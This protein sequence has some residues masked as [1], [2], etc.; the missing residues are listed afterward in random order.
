[1]S[2]TSRR[3]RLRLTESPAES[4]CVMAG[5][6]S[7]FT[8]TRLKNG[9]KIITEEI[10]GARSVSLGFWIRTGS[11]DEPA[12]KAGITHFLEHLIFKGTRS[13][14]VRDIAETFDSIGGDLNAFSSKEYTCLYARVVDHHLDVAVDVLSDLFLHPTLKQADLEAER[15]VILEEI[16]MH[17]DAPAELVHDLF[18]SA[19]FTGHPLGR[20]VIGTAD[21]IRATSSEDARDYWQRFYTEPNLI[22]AAAGSVGHNKLVEQIR[23]SFRRRSSGTNRRRIRRPVVRRRTLVV[24]KDTQQAHICYGFEGLSVKSE[25]RFTMTIINEVLGGGMSSRLWQS[26]REKYGLV[27]AVYSFRGQYA[28]TGTMGVYAGTAPDK[29]EKVLKLIQ[30]EINSLANRGI[31]KKE[32]ARAKEQLKGSLVLGLEDVTARMNRLGR[33]ALYG[34]EIL[35]I[36]EMVDR[37]DRVSLADVARVAGDYLNRPRVLTVIGPFSKHRFDRIKV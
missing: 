18:N 34:T 30:R 10:S 3:N 1:M 33:N 7:F 14:S 5:D 6:G 35:S 4:G 2:I 8:E 9:L 23:A 20:R 37:V 11:R 22:V 12:K 26:I 21:S 19:V 28:E 32:L 16:N 17:E 27:Y 36:N 24:E 13:R 15:T 25:D 29:A 31:T